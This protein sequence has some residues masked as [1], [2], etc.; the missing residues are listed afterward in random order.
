MARAAAPSSI[1]AAVS[2]EV[3]ELEAVVNIKLDKRYNIFIF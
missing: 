3:A 2:V 1:D